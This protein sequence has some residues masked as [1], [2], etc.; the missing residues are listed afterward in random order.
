MHRMKLFG[1][2]K[3][4]RLDE[5]QVIRG[6]QYLNK[7]GDSKKKKKRVP[8]HLNSLCIRAN[9]TKTKK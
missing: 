3:K 8:L 9:D 7:Y 4:M 5:I 1:R 2:E 6:I